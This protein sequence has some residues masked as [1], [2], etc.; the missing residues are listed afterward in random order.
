MCREGG[1]CRIWE[2]S[3]SE[4]PLGTKKNQ[5]ASLTTQFLQG[6]R[7]PTAVTQCQRNPERNSGWKQDEALCAVGEQAPQIVRWISQEEFQWPWFLNL[8]IYRQTLKSL[9]W[10]ICSL[11]LAV[12]FY[13]NVFL[14]VCISW[15][16]KKINIYTASSHLFG[17]IP[18]SCLLGYSPQYSSFI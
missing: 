4:W 1:Q 13:E 7:W 2:W 10:D 11:W 15:P 18:Q 5:R 8:P 6:L 14:T 16:K 17:A 3:Q 9:A 12:T